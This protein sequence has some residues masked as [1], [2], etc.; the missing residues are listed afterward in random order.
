VSGLTA[1]IPGTILWRYSLR[2]PEKPR[3]EEQDL[4]ILLRDLIQDAP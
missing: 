3:Y 1:V 2:L 4:D